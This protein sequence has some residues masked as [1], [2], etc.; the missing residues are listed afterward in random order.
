MSET[1]KSSKNL[2]WKIT[3]S[4]LF[5]LSLIILAYFIGLTTH[6]IQAITSVII[7]SILFEVVFGVLHQYLLDLILFQELS[8]QV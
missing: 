8:L 7:P 3:L 5:G 1:P 6:S 4:L 2:Q